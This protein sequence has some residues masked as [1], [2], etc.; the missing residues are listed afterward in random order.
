MT[1][2][3]IKINDSFTRK[4]KEKAMLEFWAELA[5]CLVM[6]V[7][8]SFME[9]QHSMRHPTQSEVKHRTNMA[10]ELIEEMRRTYGWSKT[11]IQDNLAIALRTRLSGL[12]VDLD[13]IAKRG[14]W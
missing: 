12:V 6:V 11:R 4:E 2:P 7:E 10:K 9:G 14:S 5:P 1:G 8:A 13:A 3:L